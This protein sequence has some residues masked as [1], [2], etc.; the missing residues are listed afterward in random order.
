MVQGWNSTCSQ[1]SVFPSHILVAYRRNRSLACD[2][3]QGVSS[4][5]TEENSHSYPVIYT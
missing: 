3:V 4:T 5:G 2:L 1:A